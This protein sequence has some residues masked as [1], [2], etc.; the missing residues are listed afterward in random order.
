VDVGVGLRYHPKGSGV[1]IRIDL[2]R[3]L[4]DGQMAVSFGWIVAY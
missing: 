2:G 4:R 1:G 3:G